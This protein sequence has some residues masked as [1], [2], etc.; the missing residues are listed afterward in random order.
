M[1]IIAIRNRALDRALASAYAAAQAPARAFNESVAET[2]G[3]VI[4]PLSVAT[5]I[6]LATLNLPKE[7]RP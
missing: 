3:A 4:K 5:R 1:A 7:T 6:R 2:C